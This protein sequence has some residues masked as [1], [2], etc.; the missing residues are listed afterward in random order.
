MYN[1]VTCMVGDKNTHTYDLAELTHIDL[2]DVIP[3]SSSPAV[4]RG[5]VGSAHQ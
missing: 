2:E 4:L 5:S 3:S 1:Q